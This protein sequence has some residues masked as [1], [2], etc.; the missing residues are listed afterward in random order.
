MA[1]DE[2][3]HAALRQVAADAEAAGDG[4]RMT[5]AL[6][7]YELGTGSD[8]LREDREMIGLLHRALAL[9]PGE[10]SAARARLEAFLALDALYSIPTPS[11]ASGPTARWRWPGGSETTSR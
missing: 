6:L 7:T 11:A 1:G 2:R 4:P 3:G 8:F 9:L 10:D 5:E